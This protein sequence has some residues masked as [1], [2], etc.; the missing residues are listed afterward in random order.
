MGLNRKYLYII[1]KFWFGIH[2]NKPQAKSKSAQYIEGLLWLNGCFSVGINLINV[3]LCSNVIANLQNLLGKKVIWFSASSLLN[4]TISAYY[5]SFVYLLRFLIETGFSKFLSRNCLQIIVIN[6]FC[7]VWS[8][9][10]FC[11]TGTYQIDFSLNSTVFEPVLFHKFR[12]TNQTKIVF[13]TKSYTENT[14]QSLMIMLL[15][16]MI[17]VISYF[18]HNSRDSHEFILLTSSLSLV[19]LTLINKKPF[20]NNPVKKFLGTDFH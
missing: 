12:F 14:C 4:S 2:L 8:D 13:K 7:V 15:T 5:F 6:L 1:P 19:V 11:S 17:L 16:R 3:Q 18:S 10:S 9:T 20:V